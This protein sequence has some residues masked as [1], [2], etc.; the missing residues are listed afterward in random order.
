MGLAAPDYVEHLLSMHLWL[1]SKRQ[2]CY[3]YWHQTSH[4]QTMIVGPSSPQKPE[5]GKIVTN[6][7]QD[8]AH[9]TC[10]Y[11]LSLRL[12]K[13]DIISSVWSFLYKWS[14]GCFVSVLVPQIQQIM[15]WSLRWSHC[16]SLVFGPHVSLPWHGRANAGLVY[17]AAYLR[18]VV[19][20]G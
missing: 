2:P 14:R 9:W 19:S 4:I 5:L 8:A 17:L 3:K 10:P 12:R 15:A 6:L 16:R 13:T 1:A 18:W 20:G 7:M 11:Y